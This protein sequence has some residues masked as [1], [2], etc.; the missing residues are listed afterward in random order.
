[1]AGDDALDDLVRGLVLLVAGDDLDAALL[2][3]RGV[4]REAGQEIQ[5][6]V[7][8]QHRIDGL[9]DALQRRRFPVRLDPPGPPQLHRQTDRAIAELLALGSDRDDVRNEQLGNVALVVLVDL[10]RRVE[11]ALARPDG[12]LRL[13]HDER[14]AIDQQHQVGPLLGCASAIRELRGD[15]VLV[16]FEV[17]EVDE[18]DGDVLA[19]LAERHGPLAAEPSGE[20][21]VRLD[22]TVA[23]DAH[24]DSPQPVQHIVCTVGL[25]GNLRVE[26][27]QRLAQLVLDQDLVRLARNVVRRE[28]VPAET[29]DATLPARET[30][31]DGRVMRD[32]AAESVTDEGFD[33]IGFGEALRIFRVRLT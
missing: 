30:W 23:P 1:M 28:K 24:E 17:V 18:S 3:V 10:D 29:G 25:G 2:L 19:P 21:L 20:L 11:P 9:F 7:R 6:D 32:A 26:A 33:R 13:D 12:R 31:T 22:Q 5:D 4:R 8:P 27:N 14:N 16:A 15:D